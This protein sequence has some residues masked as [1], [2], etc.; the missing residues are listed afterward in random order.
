MV[1]WL[2]EARAR[3]HA[4]APT[5]KRETRKPPPSRFAQSA[6][7]RAIGFQPSDLTLTRSVS[8]PSA[9]IADARNPAL[10]VAKSRCSPGVMPHT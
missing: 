10:R 7:A 6:I 4:S 3:S 2:I 5:R 1:G 9:A 8:R